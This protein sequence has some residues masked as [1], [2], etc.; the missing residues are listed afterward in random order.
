M[1]DDSCRRGASFIAKSKVRKLSTFRWPYIYGGLRWKT[2]VLQLEKDEKS[3][4]LFIRY[5]NNRGK[6]LGWIDAAKSNVATRR[7]SNVYLN[8]NAF[9]RV[10]ENKKKFFFNIPNHLLLQIESPKGRWC[11]HASPDGDFDR[12]FYFTFRCKGDLGDFLAGL[13]AKDDANATK[14]VHDPPKLSTFQSKRAAASRI[15]R[16]WHYQRARIVEKAKWEAH[17]LSLSND[18][19]P[20]DKCQMASAPNMKTSFSDPEF[21]PM[22]SHAAASAPKLDESFS[23]PDFYP[24]K[25]GVAA[26]APPPPSPET[27]S[28]GTSKRQYPTAACPICL[29]D[30]DDKTGVRMTFL[31]NCG[32]AFCAG[33]IGKIA[34]VHYLCPICRQ[35]MKEVSEAC[36]RANAH[37]PGTWNL[38][39]ARQITFTLPDSSGQKRVRMRNSSGRVVDTNITVSQNAK[40]TV[41]SGANIVINGQ[42]VE[43]PQ[44]CQHQ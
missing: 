2:R 10:R 11:S 39:A 26:S 33:C 4:R 38:T 29:D 13:H 27:S 40:I 7:L 1:E 41:S 30:F 36:D 5:Y 23:H 42:R 9:G 43:N 44:E 34:E 14:C 35:P 8:S 15:Q 17:F 31:K 28:G 37:D 22:K 19:C 16:W 3:G 21:Y 6:R 20:L 32:H 25:S 18:S 12:T 24:S